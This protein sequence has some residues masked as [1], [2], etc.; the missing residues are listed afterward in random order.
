[1]PMYTLYR[2]ISTLVNFYTMLIFVYCLMTW[3][4]M[5]ASKFIE[6]LRGVLASICEPYL[7]LFRKFIPPIAMIDFSPIVAI[8]VLQVLEGVLRA[9]LL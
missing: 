7:G 5:G 2:L 6:D 9:I 3:I 1:M 8:V 4:P